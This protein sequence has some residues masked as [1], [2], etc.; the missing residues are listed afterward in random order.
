MPRNLIYQETDRS[1][2]RTLYMHRTSQIGPA[3]HLR[4]YDR[5]HIEDELVKTEFTRG[6]EMIYKQECITAVEEL[7]ERVYDWKGHQLDSFGALLLYGTFKVVRGE[8]KN[9]NKDG[10]EVSDPYTP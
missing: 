9:G 5:E 2:E 8:T 1:S 6:N 4:S 3:S 10:R 7:R